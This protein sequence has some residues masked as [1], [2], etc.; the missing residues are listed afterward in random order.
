M[1][2]LK[3]N[4]EVIIA[5]FFII[6]VAYSIKLFSYSYSIDT[7]IYMVQKL[8][9][10]KSWLA[11]HRF[12]LVAMKYLTNWIPFYLPLINWLTI[13][14]FWTSNLFAYFNLSQI[15]PKLKNKKIAIFFISVI[16]TSPIFLE[17]FN[18]TL[19]SM[20]IAFFLNLF[21]CSVFFL[22]KYTR[23]FKY[24]YALLTILLLTCCIGSYQSFVSLF[25][26]MSMII[27]WCLIENQITKEKIYIFYDFNFVDFFKSIF[28]SW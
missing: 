2:K 7:E 26:T 1:T 24:R 16:S 22:I 13:L 19:Q 6:L 12:S 15:S 28:P 3:E 18:F 17:Q 10:L 8:E 9:M 14:L 25:I 23:N 4:K 27:D 11:I 20:E 21:E 5:S